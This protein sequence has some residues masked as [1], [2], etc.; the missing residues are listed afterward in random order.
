[1]KGIRIHYDNIDIQGVLAMNKFQSVLTVIVGMFMWRSM[2]LQF[3]LLLWF[4][5]VNAYVQY[6]EDT[7]IICAV[8]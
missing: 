8:F 2:R 4:L 7:I 1:M 5:S 3:R 6:T